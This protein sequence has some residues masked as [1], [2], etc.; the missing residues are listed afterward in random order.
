MCA[1]DRKAL[2][3]Q[4]AVPTKQRSVVKLVVV[5]PS[6]VAHHDAVG[7]GLKGLTN[8]FP[9]A[10]GLAASRAVNGLVAAIEHRLGGEIPAVLATIVTEGASR[11]HIVLG[12]GVRI[13]PSVRL[14]GPAGLQRLRGL[15]PVGL[16]HASCRPPGR[17]CHPTRRQA[18]ENTAVGSCRRSPGQHSTWSRDHEYKRHGTLSILVCR[19]SH[20]YERYLVKATP[21]TAVEQYILLLHKLTITT[22]RTASFGWS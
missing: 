17:A 22:R 3:S 15:H 18:I 5:T 9:S 14:V 11:R 13:T 2:S 4:T 16:V 6:T 19:G 8:D 21:G 7:G 20:T 10:A 1:E 12:T